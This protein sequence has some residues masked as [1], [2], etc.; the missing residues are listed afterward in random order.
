M[1]IAALRDR[2]TLEQPVRTPD[3]G[4]GAS[5]AWEPVAELWAHVRPL[6][7]DERLL[8]D[9]IAVRLTHA[10]WLRRRAGIV[11]AMRLRQG[12]RVYEIVAVLDTPNRIHLNCLCEERSP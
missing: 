8:Y 3:G 5:T 9:Q 1:R 4:G 10:V 11:P 6:S 2:L 7:G 12:E